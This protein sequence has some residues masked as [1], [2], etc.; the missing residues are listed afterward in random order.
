VSGIARDGWGGVTTRRVAELAGVN[1]GLVHYHFGSMAALRR[2]AAIWALQHEVSAPTAALLEA[3]SMPAGVRACL[4]AVAAIDPASETAS[5]LYE[6]MLA[7]ARDEELRA[8][9]GRALEAFRNLLA[10]RIEA[11]HGADPVASAAL[12]AAALDGVLLHRLVNPE[13]DV[14]S[15][16]EP[17]IEALL[18]PGSGTSPPTRRSR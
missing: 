15:L 14:A 7:A 13:F 6:A 8:E 2:E 5:V 4:D 9:L 18:L 1:P 10:A 11:A 17:L 12:V 16:A 3:P